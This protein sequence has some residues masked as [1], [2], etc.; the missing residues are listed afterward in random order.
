MYKVYY[1]VGLIQLGE[2]Q[3]FDDFDEACDF[4]YEKQD[5][6]LQDLEHGTDEHYEQYEIFQANSRIEEI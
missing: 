6:Y 2:S 3:L 5:E 4:L 1:Y